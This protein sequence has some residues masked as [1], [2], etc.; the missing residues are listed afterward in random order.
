MQP[1]LDCYYIDYYYVR[2]RLRQLFRPRSGSGIG[3]PSK[4]LR[5]F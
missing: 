1:H 2:D 5:F 3:D 4:C